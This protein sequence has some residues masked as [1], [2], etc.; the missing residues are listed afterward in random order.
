MLVLVRNR[1]LI[2]RDIVTNVAPK[3]AL[4][5]E[6]SLSDV[7]IIGMVK[8]GH[9]FI[10][11]SVESID[12]SIKRAKELGL[13]HDS[14]MFMRALWALSAIGGKFEERMEVFKGFGWSKVEILSAFKKAPKFNLF[15][16]ENIQ[17]KMEFLVGRAGCKPSYIASH[18]MLLSFNLEKRL[19]PRHCVI[20]ILKV[21]NLA[22]RE[23]DL[24]NIMCYTDK[25][26][27]EKIILPY[28][29]QVPEIDKI[30]RSAFSGQIPH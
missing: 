28:E 2:T 14:P 11:R 7:D 20:E 19:K 21:N 23:W 15:A 4:L 16:V 27:V 6:H 3:I 9:G 29:Q 12:A 10:S 22:G 18:P 13:D 17:K 26:F 24:Y 8:R 30:Y 5:K 25:T 1:G